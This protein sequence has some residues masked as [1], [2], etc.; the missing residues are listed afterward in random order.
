MENSPEAKEHWAVPFETVLQR[1]KT[2][3]AGL[4]EAEAGR[5]LAVHGPNRLPSGKRRSP[6]TRFALQFHNVLIY[7][8]IAAAVATAL[9]SHWVDTAVIVAVVVI[10]AI[11][12]F[13]QEGKAEEAMEAV[14]NMLSLRATVIRAGKRIAIDA[15][16]VVPGDIV[17]V[18]SGDKVPADIRLLRVKS[19]Q[20][21][22]AALTGESLPVDKNT[23]AVPTD[24]L[25]GDRTSMAYSGTVVTYGQGTGVVV[26]TGAATEIGRISELLAEVQTLTT[27]LLQKMDE[28]ARW[29]TIA[30]LAICAFVVA[31]GTLVWGFDLAEMFMAAVGLAVSAI[32]EGLP[33]IITITLAIGVERMAHRN[34]IVRQL[35]AVE[36][37]GSVMTI[38]SDKTGTLTRNELTVRSVVAAKSVY[39]ATG[40][41]YD[42]HGGF[43]RNGQDIVLRDDTDLMAVLRTAALCND[44]ALHQNDG[45]W[46][47]DGDPTGR[48]LVDRRGQGRRQFAR[49]SPDAA[50]HG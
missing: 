38:C 35:P 1:F 21:Q 26:A 33:A 17:Y 10:N 7:V 8:L 45:V 32:P 5:R 48:R 24:A 20:I 16:H 40:T 4:S 30:I 12:G 18:Q 44:A 6:L 11:I 47:V 23:Q 13:I 19:L 39:E 28:F 37:L 2:A 31:F 9:M 46:G 49:S 3:S 42:P 27:P 25:L 50:A 36:T 29:L 22:E 34:A 14:R 15:D 43:T 41:G